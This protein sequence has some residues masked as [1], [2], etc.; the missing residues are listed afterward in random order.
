MAPAP[1]NPISRAD[2]QGNVTDR[3]TPF[4]RILM[5]E[6]D[7]FHEIVAHHRASHS[8]ATVLANALCMAEEMG[9]AIQQIRRHL[10]LAR[11][12]ATLEQ[13]GEEMADVVISTA[14]TAR[15]MGLDL[16]AHID[17]KLDVA[18]ERTRQG[19]A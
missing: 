18:V 17:A 11:S 16:A 1:G 2:G 7:R 8:G 12:A 4:E 9:E 14:V 13:V 10:G 6:D 5:F 15:L 19:T 3:R